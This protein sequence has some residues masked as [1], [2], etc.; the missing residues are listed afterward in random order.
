MIDGGRR[1]PVDLLRFGLLPVIGFALTIWLWTSLS[2]TTLVI[3]CIW[4]GVGIAY[5]AYLTR[6]FRRPP[7]SLQLGH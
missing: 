4:L 6:G 7:P 5:L 1:E 3:G 2:S